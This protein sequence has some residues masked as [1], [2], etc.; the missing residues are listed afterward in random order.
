[1]RALWPMAR[2]SYALGCALRQVKP[3]ITM[4]CCNA[5]NS[6]KTPHTMNWNTLAQF[7]HIL[8]VVL[9]IG[10]IVFMDGFL[11]PALRRAVAQAQR[12][13]QLLYVL[14]RNFFTAIWGAGAALVITG[15][16]MV[17]LRGGFGMLSTAQ[18]VM[19]VLGSAMVLLALYI[20]FVPFLRMR[21]A[22]LRADW[23]AACAQA[24][25]I[26]LLSTANIVLAVPTILSGVWAIFGPLA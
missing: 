22:V 19:V 5:V 18:W 16:G 26:R 21:A 13:A 1:M 7:I 17:F 12:R 2:L 25:Q 15:Y 9:W 23:D 10:G 6:P 24:G 11:A 3:H 14:F 20:F 8:A 4:F